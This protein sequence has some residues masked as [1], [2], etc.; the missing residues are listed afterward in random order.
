[1]Q[2]PEQVFTLTYFGYKLLLGARGLVGHPGGLRR[3]AQAAG[4]AHIAPAAHRLRA[5]EP[6]RALVGQQADVHGR[7]LWRLLRA[8]GH[9]LC[10][11]TRPPRRGRLSIPLGQRSQNGQPDIFRN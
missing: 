5:H 2:L 7:R 9:G 4:R 8:V 10:R 6:A 11:S 1:M 3:P